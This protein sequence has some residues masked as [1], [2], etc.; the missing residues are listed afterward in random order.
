MPDLTTLSD[1]ELIRRYESNM[2][3][4]CHSFILAYGRSFARREIFK[5]GQKMLRLI[6]EY[7]KKK[8]FEDGLMGEYIVKAWC[9]LLSDF[10]EELDPQKSGPKNYQ[11]IQGWIIWAERFAATS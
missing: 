3:C 1:E 10:E 9:Y 2:R 4:D 11:D 7:L 5:R 8:K 6:A